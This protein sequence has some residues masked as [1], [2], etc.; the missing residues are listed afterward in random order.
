MPRPLPLPK[1]LAARLPE[2]VQTVAEPLV[3]ALLLLL[4]TAWLVD[5]SFNPFLYFRF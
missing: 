5:G 4:I 2:R 1:Q 3:V